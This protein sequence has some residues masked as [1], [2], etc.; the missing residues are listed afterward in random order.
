MSDVIRTYSPSHIEDLDETL[1]NMTQSVTYI[2]GCTD[3]M[4]HHAQWR[5][6]SCLI[7]LNAVEEM[8]QTLHIEEQGVL[9][10]ASLPV[11]NLIQHP[12]MQKKFAILMESCRQIGSVQIQNRATLG[13]NIAN[14]SPAGDTLPILS[15]LNAELWIGP[16]QKGEFERLS[17]DQVMLGPGENSLNGNKYIA[18]IYLPY[19]EPSDP[20]WYFRKVGQR[21]SM[22]ISKLSLAVLGWKKG[23][24]VK[25]IRICAGSVSAQV[26]RARLTEK[27]LKEND[28]DS[29][30]IGKAAGQLMKEIKP[31][32]DIRSTKK[33]RKITAGRLLQEA[34]GAWI[35][36]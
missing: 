13:G 16:R 27:L 12:V 21:F 17:L 18:F 14:A 32:G 11:T 7:D 25:D 33:Y 8:R 31:I 3:I 4:I 35:S 29:K 26:K 22:A 36:E 5:A 6:A 20:Y 9:I 34:L 2:A 23:K 19:P 24:T 28:L 10:G 30:M 1:I 15:V